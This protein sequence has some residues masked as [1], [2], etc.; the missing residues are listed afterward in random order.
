MLPLDILCYWVYDKP[1][2]LNSLENPS[3]WN[4][5][6]VKRYIYPNFC[7]NVA[8][9]HITNESG[10]NIFEECLDLIIQKFPEIT[11][12]NH[13][14]KYYINSTQLIMNPEKKAD[15]AAKKN[16]VRRERKTKKR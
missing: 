8:F 14:F 12:K 10:Y 13:N 2:D 1:N 7:Y 9:K 11:T 16:Q 6:I 3:E 4:K 5:Y 15:A